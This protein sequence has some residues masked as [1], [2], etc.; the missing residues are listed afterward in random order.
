[1][2]KTAMKKQICNE[3]YRRIKDGERVTLLSVEGTDDAVK[4][5]VRS[6]DGW[7]DS[8]P[9]RTFRSRYCRYEHVNE[10]CAK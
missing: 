4:C 8:I 10:G 2:K 6:H 1:M 7:I 9:E 5:V 3:P